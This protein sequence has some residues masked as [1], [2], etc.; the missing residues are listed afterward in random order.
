MASF[1]VDA[2][3][4]EISPDA[5]CGED[6]TYDPSFLELERLAEGTAETQVG[7]HIQEAQ[8][9]DWKQVYRISLELLKRSRDI[10][11]VLYLTA[12][13]IRRQGIA[14]FSQ[15]MLLLRSI[16]ERFWDSFHPQLDPDD[17]ND[18]LERMNI[19]SALSPPESMMSDQDPFKF[20]PQLMDVALC[21][22]SDARL[23]HPNMRQILVTTGELSVS[24]DVASSMPSAQLIDAAFEQTEIDG[25]QTTA[26]FLDMAIDNLNALDGMLVERVGAN[27]APNFNRL[28]HLLKQMRTKIGRYMERRGY[29]AEGGATETKAMS[30]DRVDGSVDNPSA[31]AQPAAGAAGVIDAPLSGQIASNRDVLKA[32]EMITAYYERNEPSSPVPLLLKRAK[33]LVGKRFIDIIRDLSPDA[34]SQVQMVS[35][36][37]EQEPEE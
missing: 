15:S 23:P 35:G 19:L 16:V 7:D 37:D 4:E 10:R 1:D 28:D 21:E 34:I 33:R 22:P 6:I 29:A 17:D 12:A 26:Q 9:P 5:P 14:G 3:L 2:L 30:E 36:E 25:L 8:E 31:E 18:P 11:V 13:L 24:G 32:L 27:S 20:I